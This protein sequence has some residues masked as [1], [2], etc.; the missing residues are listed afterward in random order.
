MN[1][2]CLQAM[3][4]AERKMRHKIDENYEKIKDIKYNFYSDLLTENPSVAESTFG[5]HRIAT[6]RWKGMSKKQLDEYYQGQIQQIM[7][8]KVL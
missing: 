1:I 8:N 7:E 6:D 4:A 3:E 5:S 2:L